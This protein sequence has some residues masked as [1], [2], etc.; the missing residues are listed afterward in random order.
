MSGRQ[1]AS[2]SEGRDRTPK[3][4]DRAVGSGDV[5]QVGT[6][7]SGCWGV[8]RSGM[9]RLCLVVTRPRCARPRGFRIALGRNMFRRACMS[10][11]AIHLAIAKSKHPKQ[12][13]THSYIKC[14]I[15]DEVPQ[16]KPS[17]TCHAL[18]HAQT[19]SVKEGCIWQRALKQ[20]ALQKSMPA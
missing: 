13:R 18:S 6:C 20:T 7:H 2:P 8:G 16:A 10:R 9:P 3:G 14:Q 17:M 15:I 19:Q 5:E 12:A 11:R 1:K 4:V